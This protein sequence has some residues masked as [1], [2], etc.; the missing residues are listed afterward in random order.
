MAKPIDFIEAQLKF[1]IAKLKESNGF[2][3]VINNP[4]TVHKIRSLCTKTL[5]QD[6]S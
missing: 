2:L 5:E 4:N 6:L 3:V 1:R